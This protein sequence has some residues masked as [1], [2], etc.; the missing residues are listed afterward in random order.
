MTYIIFS[1]ILPLGFKEV[2][3]MTYPYL[4]LYFSHQIVEEDIVYKITGKNWLRGI[5][6]KH[7]ISDQLD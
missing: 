3:P 7:F 4:I 2:F 6:V 5:V 1:Y